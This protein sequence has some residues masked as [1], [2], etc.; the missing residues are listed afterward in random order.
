MVALTGGDS[1]ALGNIWRITAKKAD[2]YLDPSARLAPSISPRAA[3]GF[4][5]PRH[6]RHARQERRRLGRIVVSA[7]WADGLDGSAQRRAAHRFWLSAHSG[8]DRPSLR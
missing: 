4:V 3:A 1:P 2:F 5:R 7:D 8:P 6:G